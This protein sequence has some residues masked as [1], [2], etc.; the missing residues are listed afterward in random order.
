M[1]AAPLPAAQYP[2]MPQRKRGYVRAPKQAGGWWGRGDGG[3]PQMCPNP[4]TPGS[5]APRALRQGRCAT[6]RKPGS[7]PFNLNILNMIGDV[8]TG[9]R[10]I[11]AVLAPLGPVLT[12]PKTF[13]LRVP[14]GCLSGGTASGLRSA[15]HGGQQRTSTRFQGAPPSRP[16]GT[17]VCAMH[18]LDFDPP[19][20]GFEGPVT[21]FKIER[22]GTCC[23]SGLA[24]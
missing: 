10:I 1:S 14:G 11:R 3:A 8:N 18:H 4:P 12:P 6:E 7:A 16:K 13:R 24:I 20:A 21:T 19:T 22:L 15:S 23:A 9:I 2:S 17:H 5:S